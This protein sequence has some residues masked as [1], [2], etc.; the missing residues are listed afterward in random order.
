ML[1]LPLSLFICLSLFVI[2]DVSFNIR[3]KQDSTD[4][5]REAVNHSKPEATHILVGPS[6]RCFGS[7]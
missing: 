7:R 5:L 6:R 4:T 3:F 1:S 2:S